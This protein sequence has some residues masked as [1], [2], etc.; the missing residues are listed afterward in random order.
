MREASGPPDGP[1]ASEPVAPTPVPGFTVIARDRV[2]STNDEAMRLAAEGA[3]DRTCVWAREQGTGRGRRGRAWFSP[4][5]NLF[6]SVIVRGR[7]HLSDAALLSFVTSLAVADTLAGLLPPNQVC[8]LK[9]P[10]DV[11]LNGGKVAGILLETEGTAGD[12]TDWVVIGCGLN[13]V[14][15]PAD[16]PYPATCLHAALAAEDDERSVGSVRTA[17][18]VERVLPLFLA[19]LGVWLDRFRREG[20]APIRWAWLD[21]AQG[22][23]EPIT[24]RLPDRTLEGLFQGVEPS[25]ALLLRPTGGGAVQQIRA[26]DVFFAPAARQDHHA[27]RDQRR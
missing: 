12:W 13:I 25:G 21:R 10:N 5:G 7:R 20:F 18:T 8:S 1:A 15:A 17:C 3:A 16:V 26:G 14:A 2:G 24:V 9:W 19:S 4:R 23:G 22:L 11:L 27:S 6:A